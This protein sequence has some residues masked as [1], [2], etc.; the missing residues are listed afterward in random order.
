MWTGGRPL[1]CAYIQ[2]AADGGALGIKL[3]E[4][5]DELVSLDTHPYL[6]KLVSKGAQDFSSDH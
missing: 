1:A 4:L 5:E 3:K 2:T 6:V